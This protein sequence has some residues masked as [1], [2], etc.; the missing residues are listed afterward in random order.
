MKLRIATTEWFFVVNRREFS[1]SGNMFFYSIAAE[2]FLESLCFRRNPYDAKWHVKCFPRLFRKKKKTKYCKV[3]P[4]SRV[5]QRW[6]SKRPCA[7]IAP[8]LDDPV[9]S[10][11]DLVGARLGSRLL[12][13]TLA[14]CSSWVLPDISR[15]HASCEWTVHLLEILRRLRDYMNQWFLSSSYIV[16]QQI[17]LIETVNL[18]HT[19]KDFQTL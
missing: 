5:A 19:S 18:Y 12:V 6:F 14:V 1:L 17:W 10:L 15:F 7:W 9:R 2:F 13:C 11:W 3:L 8:H 4:W 16:I